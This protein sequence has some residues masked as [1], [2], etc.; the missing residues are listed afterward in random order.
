M[1][2]QGLPAKVVDTL[3]RRSRFDDAAAAWPRV[4][5][6]TRAGRDRLVGARGRATREVRAVRSDAAVI[7]Q[8]LAGV[9]RRVNRVVA[10]RPP[11]Q[12]TDADGS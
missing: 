6:A 2:L 8:H 12:G 3:R 5:R 10:K 11:D 1:T 9:A 4:H 7:T